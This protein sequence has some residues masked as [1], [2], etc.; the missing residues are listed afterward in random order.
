MDK[1][2]LL[3][4]YK[5]QAVGDGK[6][7][8]NK[9]KLK[10]DACVFFVK[11]KRK[12]KLGRFLLKLTGRFIPEKIE[13]KDTDVIEVGEIKELS[14]WRQEYRPIR[15][16]GS[17]CNAYLTACSSGIPV[18]KNGKQ[19]AWVNRHCQN[20]INTTIPYK[21]DPIIQPSLF[22]GGKLE[23]HKV[24][25]VA[26]WYPIDLNGDNEMDS[27]LNELDVE[28][29]EK[30]VERD[31]V[32][33]ICDVNPGDRVWKEGRTSEY[34]EGYVLATD[35]VATVRNSAGKVITYVG[36]IF[37][38]A[39]VSGGDSSS[40]AFHK[41]NNKIVGQIFAG[42]NEVSVITP[43]IKAKEYF[44]FTFDKDEEP[45]KYHYVAAGEKWYVK[46]IPGKRPIEVR[47]NL[48]TAPRV[49]NDT[50]I[51]TL[52]LGT[53]IDVVEDLGDMNGYRWLKIKTID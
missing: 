35:V 26:E 3:K 49:A 29:E 10:K 51:K 13:G 36:Q 27:G 32:K 9:R 7:I 48:R 11:K 43:A 39:F 17:L 21:G 25:K 47:L 14:A 1:K 37:T 23:N 33:E 16:G 20:R 31:Y 28:M 46:A 40:I 22:D 8:K 44:G 50:F 38:R 53:V 45:E 30:L 18:Y 52:P 42:S 41:D 19:Y 6:K 24:G 12:D 15:G 4:K 34:T 5:A 2:T